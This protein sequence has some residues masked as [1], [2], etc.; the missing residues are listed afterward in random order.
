MY[1]IL[2]ADDEAIERFAFRTILAREFPEIEVVGEAS[3]GREV[4]SMVRETEPDVIIMDIKMPGINGIEATK[5]IKSE[6]NDIHIIM[7]TAYDNFDYV[8]EAIKMGVDD[9]ILKPSKKERIV[10]V[11]QATMEAIGKR[12]AKRE[13]DE[14]VARKVYEIKPIIES[15]MITSV[16]FGN[17]REEVSKCL[18]FLEMGIPPGY[19]MIMGLAGKQGAHPGDYLG[20]Q[21]KRKKIYD[22]IYEYLHKS[23]SCAIGAIDTGN[24]IAIIKVDGETD[25]YKSRIF[26]MGLAAELQK[27]VAECFR[28]KLV[29]GIGKKFDSI[30]EIEKSYHEALTAVRSADS[31]EDIRHYGDITVGLEDALQYPIQKEKALME[32]IRMLEI[33]AC[34]ELV[35]DIFGWVIKNLGSDLNMAKTYIVGLVV[36]VIRAAIENHIDDESKDRL[37]NKDYYGEI[38]VIN[39]VAGLKRW[40]ENIIEEILEKMRNFRNSKIT[41][42][43]EKVKAYI[44]ANYRKDITL[45]KAAE[46][47]LL[48][49]QHFSRVFKKETGM[50]FI[51]YI[52]EYRIDRAKN[53]LQNSNMNVKEISY[54]VGYNDPNYFFKV[55]KKATN[56][57]PGEFR[58]KSTEAPDSK[59]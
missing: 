8:Q 14:K 43:V 50:N 46:M 6:N 32:K 10:Q 25:E 18:D 36:L 56:L 47:V 11:L 57:T 52:T 5:I 12:R 9:Y 27:T 3:T 51:D 24:I 2:I 29:I 15:Q 49:P 22:H 21:V 45:E 33:T 4:I 28:E 35:D 16:I 58:L 38:L 26:S 19:V 55:F 23:T 30:P 54:E 53:L 37:V 1:K 48:S 7:I 20:E 40:F 59:T 13:S 31:N 41:G 39:D 42:I 44:N 17:T 34:E